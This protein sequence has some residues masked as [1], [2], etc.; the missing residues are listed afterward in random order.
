MRVEILC[1]VSCDLVFTLILLCHAFILARSTLPDTSRLGLAFFSRIAIPFT[2]PPTPWTSAHEFFICEAT[3]EVTST[4]FS[5]SL[6]Q[7]RNVGIS[8]QDGFEHSDP[9]N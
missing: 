7:G 2:H 1:V 9:D 5:L 4:V 6:S 8:K 3:E